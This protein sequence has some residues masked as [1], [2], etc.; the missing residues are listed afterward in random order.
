M[1]LL[2]FL[3]MMPVVLVSLVRCSAARRSAFFIAAINVSRRQ[4]HVG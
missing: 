1:V 3:T 2:Q 4:H